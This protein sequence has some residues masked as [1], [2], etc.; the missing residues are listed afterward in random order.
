VRQGT[1]LA[2]E[3]LRT[4][5]RRTSENSYSTHSGEGVSRR[6]FRLSQIS[7]IADVITRGVVVSAI[8]LPYPGAVEVYGDRCLAANIAYPVDAL[9]VWQYA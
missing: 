7:P 6:C 5:F 9:I 8:Q 1:K 2:D 3:L 4:P